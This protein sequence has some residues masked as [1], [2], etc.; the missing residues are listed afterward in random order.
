M[1]LRT[2]SLTLAC[3]L[4]LTAIAEARDG[5][6]RDGRPILG[7]YFPVATAEAGPAPVQPASVRPQGPT[8][9]RIAGFTGD[10]PLPSAA[11]AGPVGRNAGFAVD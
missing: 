10:R 6:E 11:P 5:G 8:E 3:S 7:S 2:L 9:T 4:T 1:L